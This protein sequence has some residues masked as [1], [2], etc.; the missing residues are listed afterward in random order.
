MQR[1]E[2]MGDSRISSLSLPFP[3][4]FTSLVRVFR[5]RAIG[6]KQGNAATAEGFGATHSGRELTPPTTV[7]LMSRENHPGVFPLPS[8]SDTILV[9]Q[10]RTYLENLDYLVNAATTF[11]Q[12]NVGWDKEF[13]RGLMIKGMG[14]E[15][16]TRGAKLDSEAIAKIVARR[17]RE[18]PSVFLFRS[19]NTLP[20]HR[21]EREDS[22]E[23]IY[24]Q[25]FGISVQRMMFLRTELTGEV[26]VLDHILRAFEPG[27]RD[28]KRGRLSVALAL[29]RHG[30]ARYYIHKT[31]NP[32]SAH[33]NRHSQYLVQEGAHPW[34][35]LNISDPLTQEIREKASE[36]ILL[37]G[38]TMLPT[39]VVKGDYPEP[40]R[41]FNP[42]ELRGGA[43][44]IYKTM[45]EVLGMHIDYEGYDGSEGFDSVAPLYMVR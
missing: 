36:Q 8:G 9:F 24:G 19:E 6:I 39:G 44:E 35:G 45:K 37:P 27:A 25:Y 16:L 40:N 14:V 4:Y 32:I 31:G 21:E 17:E 33:T 11:L 5:E 20:T 22:P 38:R 29:I 18:I 34:G 15:D 26:P 43:L 23:G 41:G 7:E 3:A 28:N 12:R 10:G 42:A 30:R 13:C 2:R 1:I